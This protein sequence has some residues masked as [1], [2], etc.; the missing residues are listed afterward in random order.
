MS[1]PASSFDVRQRPVDA[2]TGTGRRRD[3]GVVLGAAV[4]TTG[5]SAGVWFAYACSVMPALA[6]SSDHSYVE[7]MQNINVV[8]QNPVFFAAFLGAPVLAGV[9]AYGQR[10]RGQRDAMRWTAAA[11]VLSVVTILVTGAINVP[12][13]NDLADAGNPDHIANIAHVV[14]QFDGAW[15]AGNI[16]R[17]LASTAAIGCLVRA[18]M[19]RERD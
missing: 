16:V 11:F 4:V 1:M 12:L 14:S 8:I 15:V 3:S 9:A 13:N 18:L 7:V 19:L 2:A 5:L 10:R 17:L 6:R